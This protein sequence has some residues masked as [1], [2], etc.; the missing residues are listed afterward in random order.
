MALLTP[1]A[2]TALPPGALS[3]GASASASIA[4]NASPPDPERAELRKVV[5]QFEAIFLRR[6]L[7]SARAA[8]F[9]GEQLIGGPGLEQF[10]QM[11]DEQFADIASSTG[12]FGL[13][14]AIETQLAAAAQMGSAARMPAGPAAPVIR[15]G[16]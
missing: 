1:A 4:S 10:E 13:A 7:A 3:A 12:A 2:S 15:A 8:D 9:G 16:Q 14:A 5:Q 6:M 11:R